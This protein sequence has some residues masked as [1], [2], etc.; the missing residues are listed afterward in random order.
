MKNKYERGRKYYHWAK[1]L[2]IQGIKIKK[3]SEFV[4]LAKVFHVVIDK[5]GSIGINKNFQRWGF[6]ND[7][8]NI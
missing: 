1:H 3:K 5:V 7:K 2:Y 4:L 6:L 8:G